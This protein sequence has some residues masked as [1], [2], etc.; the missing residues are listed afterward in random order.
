MRA[1]LLALL[2]VLCEHRG[3]AYGL[4]P[5]ET[6]NTGALE[7]LPFTQQWD[8]GAI[9]GRQRLKGFAVSG[10]EADQKAKTVSGLVSAPTSN[11]TVHAEDPERVICAAF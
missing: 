11:E 5:Q 8:V 1:F 3:V 7:L 6:T 10:R 9:Y 2:C 4:R